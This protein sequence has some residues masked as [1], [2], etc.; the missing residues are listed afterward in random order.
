[1]KRSARRGRPHGNFILLAG[2]LV[3]LLWVWLFTAVAGNL[4]RNT[5][6][7]QRLALENAMEH[8]ISSCYALEGMYPPNLNYMKNYY[9]L[10]YD[11]ELFYVSYRPIASN[12]RPEYFIILLDEEVGTDGGNS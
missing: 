2:I 10:T 12:I 11:E 8:A 9:G 6:S 5:K 7:E 3:T 4:S 1:M